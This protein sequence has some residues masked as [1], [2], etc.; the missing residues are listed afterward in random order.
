ML[1]LINDKLLIFLYQIFHQFKFINL[2]LM[3][4]FYFFIYILFFFHLH[5]INFMA[6]LNIFL[7]IH[8]NYFHLHHFIHF[9]NY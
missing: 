5:L 7:K 3:L 9:F 6:N 4:V 8:L 2:L 1:I